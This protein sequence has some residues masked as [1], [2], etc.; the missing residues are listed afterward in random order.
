VKKTHDYVH[1]YRGYRICIY[2]RNGAPARPK[3]WRAAR[4]PGGA[5][6]RAYPAMEIRGHEPAPIREM[7]GRLGF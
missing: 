2:T 3:S 5:T 6:L 1:Y 7:D 4:C